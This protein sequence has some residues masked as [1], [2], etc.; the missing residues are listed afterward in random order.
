MEVKQLH[1]GAQWLQQTHQTA[2][3]TL[4]Q[5]ACHHIYS[6]A[7]L[8]VPPAA[9]ETDVELSANTQIKTQT[10]TCTWSFSPSDVK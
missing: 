6:C 7:M 2:S 5:S 4:H 9:S 1:E 8:A 3:A 10:H